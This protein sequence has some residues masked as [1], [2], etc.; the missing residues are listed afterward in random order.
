M[1]T[2]FW[3]AVRGSDW[4]NFLRV[5]VP[6]PFI[7]WWIFVFDGL[8]TREKKESSD[9]FLFLFSFCFDLGYERVFKGVR[10][11]LLFL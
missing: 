3:G 11:F 5:M 10:F 7:V 6:S 9:F 2:G 8:L 4:K 1:W